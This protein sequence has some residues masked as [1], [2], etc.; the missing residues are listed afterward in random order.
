MGRIIKSL[1]ANDLWRAA[2]LA[3][4]DPPSKVEWLSVFG[5][6]DGGNA[7]EM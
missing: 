5:E 1:G 2:M 7:A 3:D 6:A 4:A